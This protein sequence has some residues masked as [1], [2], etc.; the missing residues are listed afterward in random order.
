MDYKAMYKSKLT[1]KETAMDLVRSHDRI[2]V[3]GGANVFLTSL[4]ERSERL[5]G[6]ELY[7]MFMLNKDYP[8]LRGETTGCQIDCFPNSCT[9]FRNQRRTNGF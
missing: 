7:S 9:L 6:V 3:Y 4:C 1:D 8:F 2:M 5:E